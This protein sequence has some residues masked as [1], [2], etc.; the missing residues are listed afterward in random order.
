MFQ[1]SGESGEVKVG[2]EVAARLGR[3]RLDGARLEAQ[4]DDVNQFWIDSDGPFTVRLKMGRRYW[5]WKTVDLLDG[6]SPLSVRVH[7]APVVQD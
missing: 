6:G 5:V 1:V 7:G 4:A 3:W 2:Y